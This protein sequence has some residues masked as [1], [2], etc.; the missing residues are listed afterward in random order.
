MVVFV[1]VVW[2]VI[3]AHG[4]HNFGKS[5]T[6]NLQPKTNIVNKSFQL[7]CWTP[8]LIALDWIVKEKWRI[9]WLGNCKWVRGIRRIEM[10]SIQFPYCLWQY[11]G[12]HLLWLSL[13]KLKCRCVSVLWGINQHSSAEIDFIGDCD[14]LIS[15][16]LHFLE[17][18]VEI[19]KV[20][21]CF[22]RRY[23]SWC[24]LIMQLLSNSN[25][26]SYIMYQFNILVDC[27]KTLLIFFIY[28][29]II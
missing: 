24:Y 9:G 8:K 13:F 6:R 12:S 14:L 22:V 21:I 4:V 10:Y 19:H 7:H 3:T 5:V 17:S 15:A 27:G 20:A 28:Y 1:G 29:E 23:S 2:N 25:G 26:L 16:P 11:I 18:E